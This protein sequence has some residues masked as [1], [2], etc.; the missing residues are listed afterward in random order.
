MPKQPAE[1]AIGNPW[2]N[3]LERALKVRQNL[4]G[5]PHAN[6]IGIYIGLSA[7][8]VF[9]LLASMA[10]YIGQKLGLL[11]E[12]K[13]EQ[14]TFA[15][16]EDK[17]QAKKA[18]AS[19]SDAEVARHGEIKIFPDSKAEKREA[20]SA[21]SEIS[22]QVVEKSSG[23]PLADAVIA[24]EGSDFT[25]E[26]KTNESGNYSVNNIP[27]GKYGLKVSLAGF[28]DQKNPL[29]LPSGQLMTV[30]FSLER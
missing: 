26:T 19:A 14:E 20:N 2:E 15:K 24:V 28:K 7:I 18:S 23:K 17:A 10:P 22:G 11:S 9:L 21:D 6:Y 30:N 27:V 1:P 4:K 13:Q 25:S 16:S 29:I 3:P 5:Y 8:V 12:R